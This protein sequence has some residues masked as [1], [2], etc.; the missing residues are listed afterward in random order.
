MRWNRVWAIARKELIQVVRDWR[1]LAII[2]TMPIAMTLLY[3]YGVTLDIQHLP[4]CVYDREG[5]QQSQDLLKRFQ[6]SP[7]FRIVGS[8][9]SYAPI[10][11]NIDSDRCRIALVI[12]YDFSKRIAEGGTIRVQALVDGSDDNT[13]N[14][15]MGYSDAV[16][17]G[18]S[19]QVQ[20]DW[21]ARNGITHVKPPLSI[22]QRTWF[23]EGLESRAYILPGV[24]AIVMAVI[25][26]FLTSLTIAREWERGT[27]EQL[28]STPVSALELV[29]GKLLPYFVIGIVATAMCAGVSVFWFQIPF[30]GDVSTFFGT[31]A[32]FL[33]VVLAIGFWISAVARSQIVAS[34]FA[35]VA[36]FMPAFLLS[37]FI[38]PL[39][40]TPEAIQLISYLVPARYYDNLLKGV[41]LK[42]IGAGAL[43]FDILFLA[44]FAVLI[45]AIAV[46][47]FRKR[48]D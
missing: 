28:V 36:T 41:F 23:N 17:N 48:L 13:A 18:Y 32:L 5:S 27:M 3:G 38:F 11:R 47:S 10:V 7:Y 2:A 42:G 45:G 37:G 46:L 25:G 43:R 6:A 14:I 21:L 29:T 44:G 39:D 16:V 26:T 19:Q 40:Q 30:R 20:L 35:M 4:V 9:D 12:P 24:I 33:F 8:Y 15:A 22:D 1:S 31:S 34:Q